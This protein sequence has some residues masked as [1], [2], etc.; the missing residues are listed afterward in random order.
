MAFSTDDLA[1][2]EAKK[3]PPEEAPL[4]E[5][6]TQ[7]PPEAIRFSL[8]E[9]L[10]AVT[11]IGVLLGLLRAAGI[12]GAV[13]AFIATTIFTC[14]L[15]PKLRPNYLHGQ[16]A[17]FDF[18]WGVGMPLVC[19]VFDPFLFKESD[20]LQPFAM[21]ARLSV[22]II[23]DHGFIVYAFL[24]GQM[25]VMTAWLLLGSKAV[26]LA[27]F[28][29]GFLASGLMFAALVALVLV[30]PASI[31]VFFSGIGLLGLTPLI[32]TYSYGRQCRRALAALWQ[33]PPKADAAPLAV[34]GFLV[35][36]LASLLIGLA[37]LAALRG[38]EAVGNLL[39][40]FL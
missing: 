19:L 6:A 26:R 9:L 4:A 35:S 25:L 33:S 20:D 12:F 17:M 28:F 3:S 36:V 15:Y 18:L 22:A 37:L 40:D 34:F 30:I 8:R 5:T 14:V 1:D 13:L 32:T 7:A 2:W 24:A 27:P 38:S 16:Q 31:G 21:A 10:I 23:H 11:V 29:G 39:R